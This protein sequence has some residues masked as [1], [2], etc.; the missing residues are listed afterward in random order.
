MQETELFKHELK[1]ANEHNLLL[2]TWLQELE[3]KLAKESQLKDGKFL[4][5]FHREN[6]IISEHTLD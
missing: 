3:A 4:L 5:P 6:L 1:E 2:F